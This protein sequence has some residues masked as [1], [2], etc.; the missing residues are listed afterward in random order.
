MPVKVCT[1]CNQ[2][3][4]EDTQFAWKVQAKGRRHRHCKDCQSGVSK[5]HYQSNKSDYIS[6]V[7]DRNKSVRESNIIRVASQLEGKV[8]Y[9]CGDT[10]NLSFVRAEGKSKVLPSLLRPWE[11]IQ[12]EIDQCVVACAACRRRRKLR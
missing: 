4:D 10:K 8:C 3:K 5:S 1:K 6:R 9:A 12:S 11:Y 2:P 7:S